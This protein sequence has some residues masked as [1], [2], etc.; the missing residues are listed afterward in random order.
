MIC[1]LADLG[2]MRFSPRAEADALFELLVEPRSA[3]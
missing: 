1:S 3:R 2:S